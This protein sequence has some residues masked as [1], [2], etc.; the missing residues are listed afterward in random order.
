MK[1]WLG[2]VVMA[3]NQTFNAL[4]GGDPDMA[5]SARAGYARARGSRFGSA[6]C[7]VLDWLD[8][9]DGDAPQGDHCDIAI[10]NHEGGTRRGDQ[11]Q[12]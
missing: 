12:G 2:A 9:R 8:P 4:L 11:D 6:V 5:V 1:K 3:L 10:K 7:R